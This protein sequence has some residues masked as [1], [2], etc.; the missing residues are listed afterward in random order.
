MTTCIY[1]LHCHSTASDGALNPEA[2]VQL[3]FKQAVSTLALTDHD[4]TAGLN[5]A[6]ITA[7]R[8]DI[9]LIPGIEI[10]TTWNNKC[11]HIVGLNINPEDPNLQKGIK[12]LQTTRL[13]RAELIADQLEK[14]GVGK[15]IGAL[16][17]KSVNGGMVTRTHFAQ[18]LVDQGYGKNIRDIF[19]HF[20][21]RGKPGFVAT[22]WAKLEDV[23]AWINDAGGVAIIA[24]P[25]RYKLNANGMRNFLSAF[26]AAGGKAI[27]VVCG[28]NSD[29]DTRNTAELARRHGLLGS[30]GSDFHSPK[31]TWTTLGK[32]APLPKGIEPVWSSFS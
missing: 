23:I 15:N 10:S 32:L 22:R 5:E 12:S 25:M 17:M 11:F 18:Y 1:D 16:I 19:K 9:N 26:K 2:L 24:H 21:V 27:E 14:Y 4:T 31:N 8:V 13:E 6:K 20:L 7:N 30:V 28:S 3:A 29:Q